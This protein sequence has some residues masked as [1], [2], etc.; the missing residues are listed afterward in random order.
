M[1]F[2]TVKVETITV[3]S[4]MLYTL[5]LMRQA[6]IRYEKVRKLNPQQFKDIYEQNIKTGDRFDDLIDRL[7]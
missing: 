6:A 3:D 1:D 7:K 5:R 2:S 4:H